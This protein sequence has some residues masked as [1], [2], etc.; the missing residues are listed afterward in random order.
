VQ[1]PEDLRMSPSGNYIS[2]G[3]NAAAP[4]KRKG[5]LPEYLKRCLSF[6]EVLNL[7]AGAD[8]ANSR[9]IVWKF[10]RSTHYTFGSV[11][12]I[13]SN[14]R[15]N[16]GVIADELLV[17]DHGTFETTR[18][19]SDGGDSGSLVFDSE[20]Y[21]CAM[22]WGGKD[23]SDTHYVTPFEYVLEDIRQVCNAKE[24]KL[25]IRKEDETDIVFGPPERKSKFGTELD[26]TS[27]IENVELADML[28]AE[29]ESEEETS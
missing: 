20:G 23:C 28:G 19:F 2:R 12:G 8:E 11:N 18:P 17:L 13:L 22:L 9:F 14:Y 10:G 4:S 24:V 16:S 7:Q 26:V 27:L 1:G 3:M 25:V 15:S 29:S 21:V 6:E 5:D